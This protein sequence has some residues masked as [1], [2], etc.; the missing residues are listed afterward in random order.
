VAVKRRFSE[1]LGIFVVRIGAGLIR[2][3]AVVSGEIVGPT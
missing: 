1:D 3:L 2:D